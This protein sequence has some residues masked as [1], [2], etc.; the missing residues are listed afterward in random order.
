METEK[1]ESLWFCND[2]FF[3]GK[4]ISFLKGEKDFT[5][6]PDDKIV[7]INRNNFVSFATPCYVPVSLLASYLQGV[8]FATIKDDSEVS[9][10]DIETD[11]SENFKLGI[12]DDKCFYDVKEFLI[13]LNKCRFIV[14]HNAFNFDLNVLER[15]CKPYEGYWRGY[16]VSRFVVKVPRSVVAIDMM[17]ILRNN[18]IFLARNEF[19]LNSIADYY[20]WGEPHIDFNEDKSNLKE[21]C[22]QDVRK[23]R[24][25][26]EKGGIREA[27]N[28]LQELSGCDSAVWQN[29]WGDQFRRGIVLNEYLK[30]GLLPVRYPIPVRAKIIGG[31]KELK[32]KGLYENVN[33][34]DIESAY[35]TSAL[36]NAISYYDIEKDTIFPDIMRKLLELAK[37]PVLKPFVKAVAN[38]LIGDQGDDRNYFRNPLIRVNAVERVNAVCDELYAL[39][40]VFMVNTDCAMVQG[41]K[42][43]YETSDFNIRIKDSYEWAY[44]WTMDKWLGKNKEGVITAKGFPKIGKNPSILREVR[45]QLLGHLSGLNGKEAVKLLKN[46]S[47][48]VKF[49]FSQK[50]K[51]KFVI[52]KDSSQCPQNKIDYLL[53][54][55]SLP[56]GF[57][58]LYLSSGNEYSAKPEEAN[59]NAYKGLIK[60]VLN[61]YQIEDEKEL[62]RHD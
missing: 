22:E 15:N 13:A 34:W 6:I 1:S 17:K 23:L 9:F 5:L 45:Q 44:F 60:Q 26:W 36:N 51:L 42:L 53:I 27:F 61:E 41:D 57:S 47:R 46:P 48:G 11:G 25:V 33:Y 49:D 18:T 54:W 37:N 39:P 2:T 52:R 19:D 40:D 3:D 59:E 31:F 12:I 38:P 4:I 14:A 58:E 55:E 62:E 56:Y 43:D 10:F 32:E 30:R 8:K 21:K 20:G 24:F 29:Q 7:K 50:D 35:P 28:V 16:N